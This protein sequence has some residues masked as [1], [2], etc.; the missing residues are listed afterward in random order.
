[1]PAIREEVDE[2]IEEGVAMD[3]L[4][5]PVGLGAEGVDAAGRTSYRL[6]CRRMKLGEP[7]ASG[8]RAPV[9]V[10][11]SN[12]EIT[13]HRLIL[14]LGQSP[15]LTVFPEGTEV[16]EGDRLLGLLETPVYAIGDLA[17]NDGTVA[18]AIGSGRRSA[19]HIHE[20]LSGEL[21]EMT[22]HTEARRRVD[23]W[24]DEVINAGAMKMHLFERLDPG[25]GATLPMSQRHST[26][27]E[28]HQ[29]LPDAREA[30]RCLSCGVCNECDLCVT[31]CPE[32]VLKRVGHEFVFDY[33]YC[34]GCG[35]CAS[36]CPRN[37]IF[38][39]HL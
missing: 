6:R 3:F 28:I 11:D 19:F 13:C 2:A 38:M 7:D 34:K 4:T 33:S 36:E 32:G 25:E 29:G 21:L 37:V 1:M 30:K 17:T 20:A 16:R 9:E 39:S 22:E 15:D 18:G 14:A 26:F 35:I 24:R 31:Y 12:F 27:D 10:P 5:Q 8:R 23:V